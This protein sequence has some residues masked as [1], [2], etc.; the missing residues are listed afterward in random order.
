MATIKSLFILFSSII[1]V[2]YVF[3]INLLSL[4]LGPVLF[5][6]F[7]MVIFATAIGLVLIGLV[8][9]F[10][11]KVQALTWGVIFI[12]QPF[13]AVYFPINILPTFLQPIGYIFPAT[14]FFEWLRAL[15]ENVS[16]NSNLL[17]AAFVFN[18][19]YLALACW[20]FS[21][22]LASA[23]NSGQLVRNDL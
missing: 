3:H 14:Y 1:I 15:Y 11:T 12:I 22:Q 10:G 16:F 23:K 13:C 2:S 18:L 7:N 6:Y 21:L 20:I 8:F 17:V 5:A 9:Q 19:A 4:G